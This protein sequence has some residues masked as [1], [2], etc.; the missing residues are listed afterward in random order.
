MVNAAIR[1]GTPTYAPTNAG[2]TT[3]T[4]GTTPAGSAQA[5]EAQF[6]NSALKNTALDN[7]QSNQGNKKKTTYEIVAGV[8]VALLVLVMLRRLRAN[9]VKRRRQAE[10]VADEY[11]D[12]LELPEME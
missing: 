12:H 1:T 10:L 8:C 3:D 5:T 9:N 2:T 7:K 4:Q 6:G 11:K